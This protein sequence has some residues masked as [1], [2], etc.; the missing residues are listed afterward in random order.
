MP[1]ATRAERDGQDYRLTGHKWFCSAPMSDGFLTLAQAPGGLTCFL[2]PRWPEG[3]RN[4]I[5]IQRLKDKLGNRSNASA[6][7]E[8]HGALAS[9]GTALGGDLGDAMIKF[10][11]NPKSKSAARRIAREPSY[12][13]TIKTTCIATMLS[14]G[15]AENALPQSATAT[16]NC[17]IFPGVSVAEVK[18]TLVDVVDNDALEF[19]VLDEPTESPVSEMRDDVTAALTKAVHARYPGLHIGA[20]MESGGT[21]GMHFRNAGVPTLAMSAVFMNEADMFAHGLNERIPVTSFYAGLD[22]WM[23]IMKELAGPAE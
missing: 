6:E 3:T 7:I 9:L 14:A 22:H 11:D 18:A 5:H 8:Y 19:A 16:V 13:G 15:H 20:Y 4:A 1:T 2:V 17:R 12:V 10:S 21:D 23:V